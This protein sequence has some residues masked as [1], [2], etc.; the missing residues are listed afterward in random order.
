MIRR[1]V[2]SV[3]S[4]KEKIF[5]LFCF[6]FFT[7]YACFAFFMFLDIDRKAVLIK[8]RLNNAKRFLKVSAARRNESIDYGKFD[9]QDLGGLLL[10]IRDTAKKDGVSLENI[11]PKN[12]RIYKKPFEYQRIDF[13]INLKAKEG[14]FL[15]FMEDIKNSGLAV[16]DMRL[17]LGGEDKDVLG[18]KLG[19]VKLSLLY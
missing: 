2:L 1:I 10:K 3:F 4:S 13:E 7:V 5:L 17:S 18:V 6:I 19:V 9:A 11:R 12:T 15:A 8:A 14:S 16:S